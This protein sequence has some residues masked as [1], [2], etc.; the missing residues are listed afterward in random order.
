MSDQ[1]S[2]SQA[3]AHPFPGKTR[4]AAHDPHTLIVLD[5]KTYRAIVHTEDQLLKVRLD[6]QDTVKL[7]A[8][9]SE[10]VLVGDSPGE[11]WTVDRAFATTGGSWIWLAR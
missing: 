3:A 8:K 11:V 9:A 6:T 2:F 7:I 10:A 4:W 5:G 1:P